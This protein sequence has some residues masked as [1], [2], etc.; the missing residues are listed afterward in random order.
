MQLSQR[1]H[2]TQQLHQAGVPDRIGINR[3]RTAPLIATQLHGANKH[4]C[5]GWLHHIKPSLTACIGSLLPHQASLKRRP[6]V[7]LLKHDSS[8]RRQC[9]AV[10]G[11]Q[12]AATKVAGRRLHLRNGICGAL[13]CAVSC[14]PIVL[15]HTHTHT[16]YVNSRSPLRGETFHVQQ[17][18][19]N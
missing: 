5:C 8:R 3:F 13:D 7:G 9:D 11:A 4:C 1:T 6:L 18:P 16:L 15:P 19:L 10:L 17:I 2:K 12:Q 14:G